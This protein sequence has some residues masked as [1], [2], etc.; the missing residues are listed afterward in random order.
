[1]LYTMI[2][3]SCMIRRRDSVDHTLIC[4]SLQIAET[5]LS[6]A[7]HQLVITQRHA[8][9][10]ITH[11]KLWFDIVVYADRVNDLLFQCHDYKHML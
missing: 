10:V 8:P 2:V 9:L 6:A 1:M 4:L 3:L 11:E 7:N 5:S